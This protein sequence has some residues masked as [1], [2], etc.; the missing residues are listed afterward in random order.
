VVGE[1]SSLSTKSRSP[2]GSKEAGKYQQ[3]KIAWMPTKV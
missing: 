1:A 3:T 2:L